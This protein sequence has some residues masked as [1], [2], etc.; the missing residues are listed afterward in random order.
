ML[1][2]DEIAGMLKPYVERPAA[3]GDPIGADWSA[4][5]E[6]LAIYLELILRWNVRMNLTAIRQPEEIVRRHFGESL[7]VGAYLGDC[8]T[9]LDYGSGGGFP[10]IPVQIMHPELRVTLAES[11][12]KKAAFLREVIR[13]LGLR[14]EVWAERVEA[15]PFGRQ[16]DGV[17]MRAVDKMA[18]AVCEGSARTR[19]RLLILGTAG[20]TS[21]PGLKE[22]GTIETVAVPNS[23]EGILLIA[24]R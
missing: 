18:V 11:Q 13:R 6:Q 4:I 12:G 1:T 7:V 24:R 23:S 2:V 9:L 17:A 22:F 15:M 14:S 21:L 10:G 5:Y 8:A 16:F 3:S 20:L 19:R